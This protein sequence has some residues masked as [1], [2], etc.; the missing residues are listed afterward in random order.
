MAGP[1]PQRLAKTASSSEVALRCSGVAL[2]YNNGA[3]SV[4]I[5]RIHPKGLVAFGVFSAALLLARRPELAAIAVLAT[6]FVEGCLLW[7]VA[8][9]GVDRSDG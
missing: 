9:G 2:T 8:G 1:A 6:L 5:V 3:G 7:F 4:Q